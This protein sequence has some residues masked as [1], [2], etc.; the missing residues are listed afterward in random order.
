VS[1]PIDRTSDYRLRLAS[2]DDVPSLPPIERRAAALFEPLGEA[3]GLTPED[4]SHTRSVEELTAAQRAARLW[5]AVAP[6]HRLAG[7]A[8]AILLGPNAHLDELDVDPS[9]GRRG[10]GSALLDT[11][12]RWAAAA[13]HDRLT[14]STFRDVPWNRP[15][16]ERRGF[17]VLAPRELGP[18]HRDLVA[19]ERARGLHTERRVIMEYSFATP[20]ETRATRSR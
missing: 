18:E 20:S 14:L 15:F 12:V 1:A 16:Y 9:H 10:V 7:F 4:L 5:V 19:A 8:M 3:T 6:D 17:R 2:A 11:V 13:G